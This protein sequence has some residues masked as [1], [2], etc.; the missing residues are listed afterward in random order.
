MAQVTKVLIFH[1]GQE[2]PEEIFPTAE[3][4][5]TEGGIVF[6]KYI[7]NGPPTKDPD[8]MKP[9]AQWTDFEIRWNNRR[10]G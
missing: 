1:E 4:H 6:A 7:S 2:E 8:R 9:S 5:T 10:T 3:R